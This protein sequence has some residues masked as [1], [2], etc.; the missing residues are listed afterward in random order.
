MVLIVGRIP[1]EIV[2]EILQKTDIVQVVS[3]YVNLKKSGK[4]YFGLCPFHQEDTPSFSVTLDKQIFYCFGCSAG[5]NVFKFLM[6]KEGLAF[7]EA[8]YAVAQKVAVH[9]P[10]NYPVDEHYLRKQKKKQQVYSVIE[11]AAAFFNQCLVSSQGQEARKYLQNR[12]ITRAVMEDFKIGYAPAGW[13]KLIKQL[14]TTCGINEL[15]QVGLVIKNQQ[16]TNYYDRFRNRIM[17][18]IFDISGKVVGFGGRSLDDSHPKYLN[19]PETPYFNKRYLLYGLH[20]SRAAIREQ[21]FAIVL[22]GYMDVIA[23]RQFGVENVVASLGTALTKE[24]VQLLMRYTDEII[25]AYDAD[26]AG[27]QATIRGLD[28]IQQ[29]GCRVKVL[30]IPDGLDPDD[31]MRTK[32]SEEWKKLIKQTRSLVEFKL[33]VLSKEVT[34]TSVAEKIA[35]IEQVLPN[36][37]AIKSAIERE[38]S[39]KKVATTVNTSWEVVLSELKKWH[40]GN[41]GKVTSSITNISNISNTSNTANIKSLKFQHDQKHR[42]QAEYL[43]MGLILGDYELFSLAQKELTME[44]FQNKELGM[45]FKLL[46]ETNCKFKQ[47]PAQIMQYLEENA[48]QLLGRLISETI[49]GQEQSEKA[50]ILADC[51]KVMQESTGKKRRAQLLQ[52]LKEAEQRGEKQQVNDLLQELQ[53]LFCPREGERHAGRNKAGLF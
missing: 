35:I 14:S 26:T 20:L 31:Y 10:E 23:C 50:K 2:A 44:Q 40:H 1:D 48:Q 43:L 6:L 37:A 46:V 15:E 12:G 53:Q 34:P 32:G 28:V 9:I 22:E 3:E 5:G 30:R 24:Q 49:S 19:T 8:V 38:E 18:P 52:Q 41:A 36:L 25:I 51:I 47:K 42:N 17:L 45:I 11:Q 27:I 13:D 7:P 16:G 21:G 39:I 33:E 4:Y 29:L